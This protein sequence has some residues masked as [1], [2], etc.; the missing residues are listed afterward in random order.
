MKY[1]ERIGVHEVCGSVDV[2]CARVYVVSA[3]V[4]GYVREVPLKMFFPYS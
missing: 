3:C 1:I 2:V 4:Y